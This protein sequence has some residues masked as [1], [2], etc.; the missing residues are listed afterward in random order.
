MSLMLTLQALGLALVVVEDTEQL[1]RVR[2]QLTPRRLR[3]TRRLLQAELDAVEPL[4]PGVLMPPEPPGLTA[5]E[6][7]ADQVPT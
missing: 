5:G 1:D 7:A 6:P 4:E 2:A 3:G